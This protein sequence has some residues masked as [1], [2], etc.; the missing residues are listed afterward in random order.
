MCFAPTSP[1]CRTLANPRR[2]DP[3]ALP[4][5]SRR[6]AD[7]ARLGPTEA[8]IRP[9]ESATQSNIVKR[10]RAR[11]CNFATLQLRNC[12]TSQLRDASG[13]GRVDGDGRPR[14]NEK[15][16]FCLVFSVFPLAFPCFSMRLALEF[17]HIFWNSFLRIRTF[18]LVTGVVQ[19]KSNS[20][21]VRLCHG[22]KTRFPGAPAD[23]P[24]ESTDSRRLGRYDTLIVAQGVRPVRGRSRGRRP[25][26]TRLSEK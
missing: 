2:P 22:L 18:R 6:V 10:L 14:E 20:Q 23:G 8:W 15:S 19:R 16:W 7:L 11:F 26:R 25:V 1:I 3:G 12:T 5:L 24:A 21:G 9:C 4:D 13:A 17:R